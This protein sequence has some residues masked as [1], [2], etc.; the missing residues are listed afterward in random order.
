[1]IGRDGATAW[2]IAGPAYNRKTTH[3]FFPDGRIQRGDELSASALRKLPVDTGI[4]LGYVLGGEVT[5]TKSAFDICGA[6]WNHASTLY[7]MPNGVILPGN[8]IKETAIPPSS[9]VFL[10]D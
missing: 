9:R 8:R 7:R 2:D 1:M 6:R 3:Y 5:R 10:R 4:L